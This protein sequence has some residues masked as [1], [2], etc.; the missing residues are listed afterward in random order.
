MWLEMH[1]THPDKACCLNKAMFVDSNTQNGIRGFLAEMQ[2]FIHYVKALI[3]GEFIGP[4]LET[5]TRVVVNTF[6]SL[7]C[8]PVE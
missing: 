7:L 8:N 4:R 5:I 2:A 6:I 3:V 1:K